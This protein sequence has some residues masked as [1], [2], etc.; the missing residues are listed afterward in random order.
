MKFR[1]WH[2]LV[3]CVLV[4]ALSWVYFA[5]SYHTNETFIRCRSVQDQNCY[6]FNSNY[7]YVIQNVSRGSDKYL[8]RFDTFDAA[9]VHKAHVDSLLALRGDAK[10]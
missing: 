4:I 7:W 5:G 2:F 8:A 3:I 10:R 1:L 9:V 6:A